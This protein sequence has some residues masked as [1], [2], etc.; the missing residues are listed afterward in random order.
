[1]G[2]PG[3][4]FI[5]GEGDVYVAE[6]GFRA[7]MWPGTTAPYPNAPGGRVS[8]FDQRGKLKARWG[9]GNDPCAPGDFFAPHDI[10]L[11]AH[12]DIFVSEVVLSGGGNRGLVSP[13]CH[14]LQK[15]TRLAD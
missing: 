3:E 12:G 11:N 2:V 5:G 7:G 8:I 14:S 9:G 15:F 10:W 1:M 6:L 13:T 4:L